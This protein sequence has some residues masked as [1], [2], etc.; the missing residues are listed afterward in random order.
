K[1]AGVWEAPS[2]DRPVETPAKI[3]AR[4][5]FLATGK[6]YAPKAWEGA[7]QILDRYARRWSDLY[8]EACEATHVRA[9]Q[10]AEVLDLRMS[11]LEEGRAG[12]AARGGMFRRATPGVVETGVA[13][14][15]ARGTLERCENIELLRATVRPP[16]DAAAR[17]EVDRLRL[18]LAEVRALCR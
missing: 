2:G 18:A 7:S 15:A 8:V 5:A 12:L 11:C 3:E 9:E 13:A 6:G 1:L 16:A 14:A 4:E 10:S 17:A